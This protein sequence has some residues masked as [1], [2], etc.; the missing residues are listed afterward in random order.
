MRCSVSIQGKVSTG[1][2]TRDCCTDLC[3]CACACVCVCVCVSL[4][5]WRCFTVPE[6]KVA[7]FFN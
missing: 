4:R 5:V 1:L 3:V 7:P 2:T 6:T